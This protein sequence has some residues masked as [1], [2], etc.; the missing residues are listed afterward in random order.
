MSPPTG[1]AAE[2]LPT[3]Y[4]RRRY[5]PPLFFFFGFALLLLALG[6][7]YRQQRFS[8]WFTVCGVAIAASLTCFTG[9]LL[10]DRRPKVV[11][12]HAG[13]DVA[14]CRTG[15]IAWKDIVHVECFR[16]RDQGA[17]A[18]FL[19]PEAYQ[20][21]PVCQT[22]G[23][24]PMFAH[25]AFAGPPVWFSDGALEYSAQELAAEIDARRRGERGPLTARLLRR[26]ALQPRK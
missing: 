14:V 4:V 17:V 7:G 2:K 6:V 3:I 26:K 8:P 21:L 19:T 13:I 16:V 18:I 15:V 1:A 22:D 9:Y 24:T 10:I 25:E 11:F 12:T 23:R 5:L 20:R